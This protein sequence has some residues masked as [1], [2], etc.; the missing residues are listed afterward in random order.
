V[1][2]SFKPLNLPDD[3][4]FG[5]RVEGTIGRSDKQRLRQLAEKCLEQGKTALV[6]DFSKL[7]SIGGG[8]AAVLAEFQKQLVG[9]GGESVVVGASEMVQHFLE[10]RFGDTPLRYFATVEAAVGELS[11]AA[12][13]SRA[14]T[15]S[16][17]AET[18][19]RAKAP[20]DPARGADDEPKSAGAAAAGTPAASSQRTGAVA[21][22]EEAPAEQSRERQRGNRTRPAR[23]CT[24]LS[25]DEAVASV[26][27]VRSADE[28]GPVLTGLLRGYDLADEVE[29]LVYNDGAY[30]SEDG[31]LALP[32]DGTLAYALAGTERPLTLLDVP[33]DELGES[34]TD[35]LEKTRPDLVLP[36]V[37]DDTLQAVALLRRTLSEREYGVGEHF[38]LELLMRLVLEHGGVTNV[39][40]IVA[41]HLGEDETPS[42]ADRA[43][44][45][46]VGWTPTLPDEVTQDATL[47]GVLWELATGLP[48]IDDANQFWRFVG[49]QLNTLFKIGVH[50]FVAADLDPESAAGHGRFRKLVD[51]LDRSDER[52]QVFFRTLEQPVEIANFPHSLAEARGVLEKNGVTWAVPVRFDGRTLG[53]LLLELAPRIDLDDP[54]GVLTALLEVVAPIVEILQERQRQPELMVRLLGLA[55]A[56]GDAAAS[57]GESHTASLVEFLT[58]L[59]RE[60]ELPSDQTREIIL[61][62]LL[63]NVG[64]PPAPN[65]ADN[66]KVAADA[67][68]HPVREA[69]LL[70]KLGVTQ[71]VLDV[72]LGH[73]ERFD[74]EGYPYGLR[75]REIP[76]P[77]RL[78]A[79]AESFTDALF[80]R[81]PAADPCSI[82]V[83][84]RAEAVRQHDPD[85]VSL[86]I[87]ALEN[88]A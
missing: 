82:A 72:V 39:V 22:C 33:E 23:T 69:E 28:L 14:A 58:R 67:E 63:R 13:A 26:R 19:A 5:V 88:G 32:A 64:Q 38:A 66:G 2:T 60:V 56:R 36:I 62:A 34:E 49:D 51:R 71:T 57:G 27:A 29:F 4:L 37:W 44:A 21:V 78:V 85:I 48:R 55:F 70:K 10:Q 50:G 45:P 43:S 52:L 6:L 59:A 20:G 16:G 17:A 8:G 30:V 83:D 25:L 9:Q 3:Q 46:R 11:A 79:V 15:G 74:G 47:G 54:G 40:G 77:A 53:V 7:D 80:A 75:G 18:D 31:E 76:L 61:G 24:F 87:K 12:G 68:D 84:W 42:L 81:D 35:V 65:S 73:H 86:F 1:A 41:E